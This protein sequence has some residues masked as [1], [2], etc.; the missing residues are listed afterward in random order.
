MLACLSMLACCLLVCFFRGPGFKS[1]GLLLFREPVTTGLEMELV[2]SR[3]LGV[4][5]RKFFSNL[6]HCLVQLLM[7]GVRADGQPVRLICYC[8]LMF[9]S[10]TT[11]Y[12][13]AKCCLNQSRPARTVSHDSNC[14]A[15]MMVSYTAAAY[16]GIVHSWPVN[17]LAMVTCFSGYI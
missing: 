13:F 17:L 15:P 4:L 8:E 7:D 1:H 3:K 16:P 12:C 10:S 11:M 6:S 2:H 5:L 14:S 9:Q